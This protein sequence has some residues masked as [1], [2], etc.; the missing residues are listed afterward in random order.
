MNFKKYSL[1]HRVTSFL[2]HAFA[3]IGI[4]SHAV[5]SGRKRADVISTLLRGLV[6]FFSFNTRH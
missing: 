3:V 1:H 2:L 5:A 4:T 6:W